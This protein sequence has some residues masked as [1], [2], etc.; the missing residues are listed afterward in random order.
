MSIQVALEDDPVKIADLVARMEAGDD[1]VFTRSGRAT[2]RLSPIDAPK[3][4]PPFRDVLEA[5]AR[6]TSAKATPGASA[7]RSQDMLYDENG[8]IA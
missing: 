3:R 7:A 2:A 4:A 5:I 1:V 6:E 8:L